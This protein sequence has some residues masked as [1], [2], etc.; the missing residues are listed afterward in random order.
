[1]DNENMEL[2]NNQFR[3]IG[4]QFKQVNAKLD[5]LG[6]LMQQTNLQEYR[7][8]QLEDKLQELT[9]KNSSTFWRVMTPVLSAFTAGVVSYIIS[10]G[11][12]K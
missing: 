4:D 9:D 3:S 6:E 5:K 11:L 8:Q 2:I 12:T 10:G 1:M 7:I